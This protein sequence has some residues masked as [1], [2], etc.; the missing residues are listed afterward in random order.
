MNAQNRLRE[1]ERVYRA[2][3]PG[4][5]GH[6]TAALEA[7]SALRWAE[8]LPA[9]MPVLLIH[10]ELDDRVNVENSRAMAA[11]LEALGRPH[12]LVVYAGDDHG[13]RQHRRDAMGEM[14]AWF[15]DPRPVNQVGSP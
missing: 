11:R 8:Q 2:R 6:E 12:K 7:R 14:L 10:G 9:G 13:V 1:M 3:I 5:D 4:Y 15:K